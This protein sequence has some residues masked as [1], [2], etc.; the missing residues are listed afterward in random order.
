MREKGQVVLILILVMT[1][2]LGIGISVVQRSLSDVST[3]S[4]IEQSSRAF[5]AAEAGIE[6]AIQSG[7]TV[8][9]FN[10]D[11]NTA[12]VDMQTVPTGTNALEY[13]PL[14]KEETATVWL[15][16][17]DPNVQLPDCTAIDP[18][19]HSPACY[20]QNSLNV[21]W[22]NSTTD[23]AALELTLVYYSSSQYQS[24]KW[25]LDQITR[26]PANNFDIV[27]TCAG[28]LG[29]GSKYQ[30]SKTIDWS[31]LGTVTP[32]LIRARLLYNSTSQPVAVAPIGLG[33]LPAQ[34]SIFT[35][36]GTSG[37][38]QRKIQVFRLDKVVPSFFDY[39]I[40]S[41]GTITK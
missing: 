4:K 16:D 24:Q 15:A 17:P 6:K 26:T 30:C 1:V 31:S 32:M 21:Y 36:T 27:T 38:T 40:F 12:S 7:A 22:G 19:K 34:G 23:R 11:S 2:A 14:A 9:E 10:L 13:P 33:S 18:T 37:Q 8:D 35:A 5:S 20:Q 39:A 25:Y 28:S 3:A 41:A 29:P